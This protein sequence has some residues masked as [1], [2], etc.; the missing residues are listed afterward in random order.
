MAL[1]FEGLDP[2]LDQ[3]ME[4][5]RTESHDGF[6]LIAS[7]NHPHPE[8]IAAMRNAQDV[9]FEGDYAEGYPPKPGKKPGSGRFYQGVTTADE[10]E[11]LARQRVVNVIA[12]SNPA[13]AEANV[14]VPSGAYANLVTYLGVLEFGDAIVSP[15]LR[16]GYGHLSHGADSPSHVSKLFRC[17]GYGVNPETQLIDYDALEET[18][19]RE[20]PKLIVCGASSY[21]RD[22]DME[23]I[24]KLGNRYGAVTMADIA[25][26]AGLIVA[27]VLHD[28]YAAG[29]DIITTTTQKTLGGVKGAVIVWNTETLPKKVEAWGRN[30]PDINRSVFPC[31]QGGPHL[32]T[33][34]AHASTFRRAKTPAFEEVQIRTQQNARFFAEE[35]RQRGWPLATGGTDNHL[36]LADVTA[37]D[38]LQNEVTKDG[39][40]A[41]IALE[42]VGIVTNKN[43][44]P[45]MQKGT[46]VRPPA[47]RMGTPAVSTRGFRQNEIRELAEL[48]DA[49]LRYARD[50]SRIGAIRNRVRELAR[51]FPVPTYA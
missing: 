49:T 35:L 27:N 15:S 17:V 37:I 23:R 36:V 7:E 13:S 1:R 18:V 12:R 8:D 19:E 21:P 25:H 6:T 40:A 26:P 16:D 50:A 24:A 22:I 2:A 44:I 41:A 39:W 46:M 33:I 14:Q 45:G 29:I 48:V 28:P 31:T 5:R 9:M 32:P 51:E 3:V 34:A 43:A 30:P 11:E 42:Q 4:H 47:L 10:L 20:Q 38:G